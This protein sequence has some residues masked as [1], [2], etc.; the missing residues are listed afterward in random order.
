MSDF[1]LAS[2]ERVISFIGDSRARVFDAHATL[3]ASHGP[4]I[5]TRARAH[6]YFRAADF[7]ADGQLGERVR[8]WLWDMRF[9]RDTRDGDERL[10]AFD[11][12]VFP[13]EVHRLQLQPAHATRALVVSCGGV[14]ATDV[15]EQLARTDEWF[16]LD[17][18][19]ESGIGGRMPYRTA[20]E[21]AAEE[22]RNDARARLQPLAHGLRLLRELGFRQLYLLGF[23]PPSPEERPGWKPA[24]LRLRTRRL[25]DDVFAEICH[26]TGARYIDVWKLVWTPN[27]RDERLYQDCGHHSTAM[28]PLVVGEVLGHESVR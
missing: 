11:I 5:I 22:I 24:G 21:R 18:A 7:F 4:L 3:A 12:P 14:D 6:P 10:G 20:R 27:G 1:S 13:G 16:A 9:L 2:I 28:V 26:E 19:F 23:G 17:S 15:E 8:G 25:F